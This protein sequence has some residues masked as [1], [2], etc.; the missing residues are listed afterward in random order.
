MTVILIPSRRQK[1]L[2]GI[3]PHGFFVGRPCISI[4]KSISVCLFGEESKADDLRICSV[5]SA[6]ENFDHYMEKVN[7][8]E[9]LDSRKTHTYFHLY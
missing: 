5:I 9:P 8:V 6:V 7:L 1:V 3:I 4:W 2:S